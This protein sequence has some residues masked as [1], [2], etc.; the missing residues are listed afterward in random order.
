MSEHRRLRRERMKGKVEQR[1]IDG[2]DGM[3]FDWNP[4]RKRSDQ[5]VTLR[6]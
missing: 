4:S 1:V 3:G 5:P 6:W 2:L